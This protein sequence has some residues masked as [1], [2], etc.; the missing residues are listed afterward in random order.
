M[1]EFDALASG[2]PTPAP[3]PPAEPPPPRLLGPSTLFGMFGRLL[4]L[5]ALWN[6]ERMQGIGFAHALSPATRKLA[7]DDAEAARALV[8]HAGFFNT[9]PVMAGVALGVVADQLERRA[10]GEAGLDDAGVTRVKQALGSS[11]AA[12][13]DPLFWNAVRPLLAL[14]AIYGWRDDRSWIGAVT[15]VAGYNVFALGYRMRGLFQGYA[16]GLAYVAQLARRLAPMTAGVRTLAAV[17]SALVLATVLLPPGGAPSRQAWI[18]LGGAALGFVGF[19]IARLGP[20][21]WGLLL[22]LTVLAWATLGPG[23]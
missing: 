4:L 15:I 17:V 19:G 5:Q 8:P 16:R 14:T 1:S 22:V 6:Y 12:M 3:A 2:P 20:G 7:K 11:L 23:F 9:H 10:R 18:A 21:E 13:G